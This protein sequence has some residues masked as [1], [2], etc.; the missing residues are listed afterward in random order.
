MTAMPAW[1]ASHNDDT[2]WSLVTFLDKI[3]L[4]DAVEYREL[5]DRASADG[6]APPQEGR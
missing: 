2:I 1:G 5:V 4:L 6:K 3:P